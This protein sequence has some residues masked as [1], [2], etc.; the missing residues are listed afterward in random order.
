MNGNCSN[1][2]NPHMISPEACGCCEGVEIL[3]PLS[4]YNRPGLSELSY[5]IGTH[6]SFMETMIARL[7]RVK[8]LNTRSRDD[9]ALAMLDA[10]ATVADVLTFYQERIANENYLRTATERRSV[11]ELARL[12][13]YRPRPGV[14]SSVFL[15]Y[16]LDDNHKEETIIPAGSRAQSIPGPNEFP[17]TFETSEPLKAR[18]QWNNLKPRL[19]RPQTEESIKNTEIAHSSVTG[20]RVYLK[21]INT[22]LRPNDPLLI[23][24]GDNRPEF[25]RVIEVIPDAVADRTLV[26]LQWVGISDEALEHALT[27]SGM[28]SESLTTQKIFNDVQLIKALTKPPSTQPRNTLQL[29]RSTGE[30]FMSRADTGF[31]VAGTFTSALKETLST[32]V[33]NALA[34][35][36]SAIKVYALRIKASLFGHNLPLPTCPQNG[37]NSPDLSCC[38]P[39]DS[40]QSC[41][42][43]IGKAVRSIFQPRQNVIKRQHFAFSRANAAVHSENLLALDAEYKEIKED[44][45]VAIDD[46]TEVKVRK[47]TKITTATLG[48]LLEGELGF[49]STCPPITVTTSNGGRPVISVGEPIKIKSTILTLDAAWKESQ[50]SNE[51]LRK[52]VFYGQSEELELANEPIEMPVCGGVEDLIELDGFYDGLQS[53]RWVIVSGERAIEGTSGVRFSELAMLSTVLQ[54]VS[55]EPQESI[56]SKGDHGNPRSGEKIHTFIKLAN[57]LAYCFKRDTVTIYGNVIKATHGETR[58][59]V[60]GS[61]DGSKAF[62]SF[63]LRQKPLTFVS[64]SNPAGVNSTLKV[65]VND[66]QWGETDSLTALQPNDRRFISK[67]DNDDKT[68]IIFGNGKKGARLPTGTENIKAEYRSGIGKQGNV[69]AGQ[70]SLLTT[71]PLGVKAVINPLRASGG[72]NRETGDQMRKNTPLAVK[73][74]D[75]L[76]S[77]Q[78]YEDF[79]RVYAGIGKAHAVELSN[80]RQQI[81]HVTIAGA[82]D[83]PIDENSDLFNNLHQALHDLGDPHQAIELAIRELL[84][85]VIEAGVAILPNYQWEPVIKEVRERLLDAF[86]FERRELGQDVVLSEVISVMQSVRGVDYVDVDTFGGIPEKI[87]EDITGIRRLLT[88]EEIS[89]AVAC[90]AM[91]WSHMDMQSFCE[92]QVSKSISENDECRKFQVCQKYGRYDG[93]KGVRQRLRVN[94]AEFEQG[95][96]I[97]PA[98]IAFLTP[99]VPATLILNQ[100]K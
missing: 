58:Q 100:I 93:A 81:V 84:F 19:T 43:C 4:T 79:C 32:A 54:D 59:E 5:R 10:W 30:Q 28:K 44:T 80:G 74:L 63:D 22:N 99:D 60:L 71:K 62:Q 8:G 76:V 87:A 41:F 65:F 23:A 15:A 61:G 51:I 36:P 21:G 34:S 18:S 75:R 11:L 35:E 69:R 56:V 14:S 73:A 47:A 90:L 7:T 98:Q 92:D 24:M 97:R 33:G 29:K 72:A 64:A 26:K 20:P 70:I 45:W 68:T 46:G 91:R 52:T 50:A 94:L 66:V 83:I 95:G 3:T 49:F 82:E 16:T 42:T 9:P 48:G 13:G 2:C 57:E 55:R 40:S 96:E 17:Q 25:A 6:G 38:L 12:V 1:C 53:G 37:D 27:Q 67:T 31:K 39:I 77:V 88:P 86:S 78:D 85:I 89:E